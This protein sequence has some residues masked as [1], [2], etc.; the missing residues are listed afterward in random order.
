MSQKTNQ[1]L[2]ALREAHVPPGPFNVTPIFAQK[3]DGAVIIDVEG[4]E[5]IDF[6]SGIGVTNVGHC[7]PEVVQAVKAQADKFLHTC[8]H[9]VQYEAYIELARRLNQLT[10]GDFPKKTFFANSGAEAVENGVKVARY[11]TKRQ[12]VI[13]F[14]NA[15]H[16]RTYLAMSLTSKVKPYKFGFE[17]FCPEIYRMPYAY[18]YRCPFGLE[19]PGCGVYCAD[20]MEQYFIGHVAGESAA[21]VIA[22]PVQGEG[23]FITPPPEYF[24]K[25][26]AVCEKYGI[27]FIMDEVQSGMGRTGKLFAS[28]H[29]GVIPDIILT[30]KSL[31]AGLPLSAVTGR[32]ELMDKPHVGGL[33]GTYGGNPLSCAAALKVLDLLEGGLVDQG[34]RLGEKVRARF[35]ELQKEFEIIGEVRGLGPMLALELVTDR[36]TKA[37]AAD[38]AKAL[39]KYGYEHG[40]ILLSCGNLSNVIRTLMPLSIKDE[41][42]ERGLSILV[43]G[44]KAVS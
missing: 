29:F 5:Y 7:A 2:L 26:K 37:P 3:A 25:I 38:Q 33:G 16:G 36:E 20:Y 41:H 1:E 39:V 28:E 6:A 15:F 9:V 18:C 10:P 11:A 43:D 8:F 31:A 4:K 23:G 42:L 14:D 34:A 17:P 13:C 22:E 21:A 19:Y 12:A 44:L 40:L 35:L 24:K 30:A 32:A 27:V